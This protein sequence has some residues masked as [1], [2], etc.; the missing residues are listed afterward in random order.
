LRLSNTR[1]QKGEE[2]NMMLSVSASGIYAVGVT[3]TEQRRVIMA[4]TCGVNEEITA[5]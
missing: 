4:C 1:T 3:A 2:Y 5:G